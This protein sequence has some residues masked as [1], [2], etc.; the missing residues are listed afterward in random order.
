MERDGGVLGARQAPT[1]K[2]T[3]RHVEIPPVLLGQHVGGE[4]GCPERRVKAGVHRHGFIDAFPAV[5][6]IVTL[7]LLD[8]RQVVGAVAID[9]VRAREAEGASGQ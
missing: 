9:L 1:A 2:H 4:L 8:Q 3:Y 7:L 5:G 6:V